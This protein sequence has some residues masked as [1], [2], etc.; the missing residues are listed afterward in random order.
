MCARQLV[1][2]LVVAKVVGSIPH[3]VEIL[4]SHIYSQK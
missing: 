2:M 4:F 1:A 3:V